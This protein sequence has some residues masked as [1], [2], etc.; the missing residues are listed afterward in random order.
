MGCGLLISSGKGGAGK[1]TLCA[2]LGAALARRQKRVLCVDCAAGLR[3]LD[4]LMGLDDCASYHLGDVLYGSCPPD[5]AIVPHPGQ[6][7]LF[8]LPAPPSYLFKAE[9]KVALATLLGSLKEGFDF[10]LIDGASGVNDGALIGASGAD[11]AI[12]VTEPNQ[13]ALR[14]ADRTALMLEYEGISEMRVVI[15]KIRPSLMRRSLCPSIDDVID[16]LSIGLLGLIPDSD[17][18]AAC[19][20]DPKGGGLSLPFDNMASRLCGVH[21]PVMDF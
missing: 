3:N 1:T 13:V 20:F 8:L 17:E 4:L 15:N 2:N 10:V 18:L 11:G 21:V 6:K 14:D 5:R 9:D 7:G 12:I 19:L 16:T